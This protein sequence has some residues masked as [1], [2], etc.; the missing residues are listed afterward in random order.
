M[1]CSARPINPW[2]STSRPAASTATWPKSTPITPSPKKDWQCYKSCG[3]EGKGEEAS[4][5]Y[6]CPFLILLQERLDACG[7]GIAHPPEDSQA[8]FFR[9]GCRTRVGK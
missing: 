6:C 5:S 9:T 2:A 8:L 1:T 4:C 3:Q 7:N